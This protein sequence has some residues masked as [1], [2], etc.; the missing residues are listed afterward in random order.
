MITCFPEKIRNG[1]MT[2]IVKQTITIDE[3]GAKRNVEVAFEL[4][5]EVGGRQVRTYDYGVTR[6]STGPAE[7]FEKAMSLIRASAE[8]VANTIQS[9]SEPLRPKEM[10]IEFGVQLDGEVGAFIAK[11][12]VHSHFKVSMKWKS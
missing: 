1:A 11:T 10:G 5:D 4:D 8:K 6:G 3:N 9:V 7:A 2:E 12:G